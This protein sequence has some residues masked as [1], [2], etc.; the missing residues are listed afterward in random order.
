MRVARYLP[1]RVELEVRSETGGAL[2]L[3]DAF[4]SGWRATVDGEKAQLLPANAAARALLLPA[5]AHHVELAFRTPGLRPAVAV[6]LLTLALG[7]AFAVAGRLRARQGMP[8]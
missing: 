3:A 1:E 7:A 4:Y 6:A 2:V 5:G 8:G